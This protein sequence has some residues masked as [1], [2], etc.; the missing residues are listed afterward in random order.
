MLV[1]KLSTRDRISLVAHSHE[2]GIT[3][4]PTPVDHKQMIWPIDPA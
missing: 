2:T 3:L 1:G 4:G